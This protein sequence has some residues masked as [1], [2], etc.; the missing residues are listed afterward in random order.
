MFLVAIWLCD[1]EE[2]CLSSEGYSVTWLVES[3]RTYCEAVLW[4]FSIIDSCNSYKLKPE[5]SL[6]HLWF[7]RLLTT[8]RLLWRRLSA[9]SPRSSTL[10]TSIISSI[11]LSSASLCISPW[12]VA[13]L[14]SYS[15]VP[16]TLLIGRSPYAVGGCGSWPPNGSPLSR[17]F[18]SSG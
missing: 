11:T 4:A 12:S 6:S 18:D 1:C 9:L 7:S 3:Y 17:I 10:W 14:Y 2:S 5:Y 15:V 13:E 16:L 8:S